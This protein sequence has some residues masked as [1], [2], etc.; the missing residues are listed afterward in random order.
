MTSKTTERKSSIGAEIRKNLPYQ[1]RPLSI[2]EVSG[3]DCYTY[4]SYKNQRII[5][6]RSPLDLC[7]ALCFEF[8]PNI[9]VYV[10][11]PRTI[12]ITETRLIEISFWAKFYDGQ[13]CLYLTV[14]SSGTLP[15]YANSVRAA[16]EDLIEDAA[17]RHGVKIK[18]VFERDILRNGKNISVYFRLL[19]YVNST[20][21]IL[22]RTII[23][24]YITDYFNTARSGT[25]HQL[26]LTL[27]KFDP[28]HVQ[29]VMA[30][31]VYLGI[32]T[33]TEP[34]KLSLDTV[35]ELVDK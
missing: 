4:H 24:E 35:F 3:S 8:E 7:Q 13:E 2:K 6:L 31:M 12:A 17:R 33:F 22:S 9:E 21:R 16:E 20:R 32:L 26:Q 30:W 5:Q 14:P 19:P 27:S 10:E 34:S 11:R 18:Y 23:R 25:V 1:P 28:V 15:G 29:A